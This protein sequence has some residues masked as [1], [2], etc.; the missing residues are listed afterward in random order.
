MGVTRALAHAAVERAKVF[1]QQL[2]AA[3]E[4]ED[5]SLDVTVSCGK[6]L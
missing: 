6:R 5:I 1:E 2:D 4:I 3:E